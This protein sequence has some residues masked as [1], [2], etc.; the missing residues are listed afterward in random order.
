MTP[1]ELKI[2][3]S[4]IKI[5]L[6]GLIG[7]IT[8]IIGG[9]VAYKTTM[10][11]SNA[12]IKEK[13]NENTN[14]LLKECVMHINHYHSNLSQ[15]LFIAEEINRISR[16]ENDK[17]KELEE[18]VVEEDI[19]KQTENLELELN[20]MA[21]IIFNKSNSEV[22]LASA[23]LLFVGCSEANRLLV[24]YMASVDKFYGYTSLSCQSISKFRKRIN[25]EFMSVINEKSISRENSL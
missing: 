8:S 15:Y 4:T 16:R 23:K 19:Q 6:G 14:E 18:H 25:G 12:R 1:E 3:D 20:E 7:I 22:D 9:F 13:H 10:A 11:G 21:D 24:S 5:G 2:L 17:N